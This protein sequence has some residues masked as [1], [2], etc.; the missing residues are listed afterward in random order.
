VSATIDLDYDDP[1]NP[2]LHRYHPDHD[3][4][5]ARYT[6]Q[7]PPGVESFTIQRQVELT[8]TADPP[9]ALPLA[10]WGD[11][12]LGGQYRET[13]TGV[14]AEPIYIEGAFRLQ[15]VSNISSINDQE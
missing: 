1:L 2:F 7:L 5:N 10:G 9:D 13:I 4:L 15:K 8:F 3:N 6:Q 11:T 14:H 12:Q